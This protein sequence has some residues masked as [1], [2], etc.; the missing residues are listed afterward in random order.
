MFDRRL[1]VVAQ[2]VTL[3]NNGGAAMNG[4]IHL[5]LTGLSANTALSNATGTAVSNFPGS[6]YITV[7][8]GSL[9]AGASV[10][11]VLNFTRPASGGISYG[12][13]VVNGTT[14]P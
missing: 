5:V 2:Q 9:A 1:N 8:S 14:T 4:P 13:Q 6:P 11:V 12:T 7:Q 3:T 10:N